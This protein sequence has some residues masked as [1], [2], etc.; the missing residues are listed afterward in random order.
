MAVRPAPCKHCGEQIVWLPNVAGRMWP[1]AAKDMPLDSVAPRDR[2]GLRVVDGQPVAV[3]LDGDRPRHGRCL[4][5]HYCSEYRDSRLLPDVD[6][7]AR[8][9]AG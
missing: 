6:A 5:S 7:L 4:M 2:Y 9:L 1:F 3:P 8:A